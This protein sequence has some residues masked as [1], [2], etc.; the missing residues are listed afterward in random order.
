[1]VREHSE[2]FSSPAF[3]AMS[4][5]GRRALDLISDE[6]EHARVDVV[7]LARSWFIA[8]GMS[9]AAVSY[10]IRQ[11]L[12]LGFIKIEVGRRNSHLFRLAAGWK[13]LDGV[14]AKRLAEAAKLP[15]RVEKLVKPLPTPKRVK[16]VPPR[17][18]R[19]VPSLPK[20]S[21]LEG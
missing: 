3:K 19:R 6:I 5:C 8:N 10:G 21:F 14:E 11:C 7:A 4:P 12:G 17:R 9:K 1:M 13:A 2:M 18:V 15:S 16:V 20:L